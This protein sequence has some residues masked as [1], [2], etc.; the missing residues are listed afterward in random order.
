MHLLEIEQKESIAFASPG[1][2][3][4]QCLSIL[5]Q[6]KSLMIFLLFRQPKEQTVAVIKIHLAIFV[7][8]QKQQP[9]EY[10]LYYKS[11]KDWIWLGYQYFS[12]DKWWHI[13]LWAIV[14]FIYFIDLLFAW[15]A[16]TTNTSDQYYF[17]GI[18]INSY[19]GIYVWLLTMVSCVCSV[20]FFSLR[21]LD[22][23]LFTQIKDLNSIQRL[24]LLSK[25]SKV[26]TWIFIYSIVG[27]FIGFIVGFGIYKQSLW[28]L[29]ADKDLHFT[30]LIDSN[31][32]LINT[33]FYV[34]SSPAN[35]YG[36]S[37]HILASIL[38]NWPE[39]F[40]STFVFAFYGTI[41]VLY[42]K[43][44]E[45]TERL[46]EVAK[47][48]AQKAESDKQRVSFELEKIKIA[49]SREQ[50][51]TKKAKI[52]LRLQEVD[53]KRQLNNQE[54]ELKKIEKLLAI[55]AEMNTKLQRENELESIALEK[56]KADLAKAQM[57]LQKKQVESEYEKALITQLEIRK[58][59]D[60]LKLQFL[61]LGDFFHFTSNIYAECLDLIMQLSKSEQNPNKK[62]Q[63]EKLKIYI[64]HSINL[65]KFRYK[66]IVS[67]DNMIRLEEEIN[68][69]HSFKYIL[70]H[71]IENFTFN[72]DGVEDDY[73]MEYKI[74][75]GI[76]HELVWNAYKHSEFSSNRFAEVNI[77]IDT[78]GKLTC[79]II[80]SFDPTKM[81]ESKGSGLDITQKR[82][83]LTYAKRK[84][85]FKIEEPKIQENLPHPED[86]NAPN[87]ATYEINLE[88]QLDKV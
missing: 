19:E 86:Y 48:D 39:A 84:K 74:A 10:K 52:A 20:Y 60:Q 36:H 4:S 11:V 49:L 88:I 46:L 31:F 22:I 16:L 33:R 85:Y 51:E 75:S 53:A 29:I 2:E 38:R 67:K 68:A 79:C 8:R 81:T 40:M 70:D 76:I 42:P 3:C 45:N 34:D 32:L 69:I 1:G 64:Q 25:I 58:E 26:G 28:S 44:A 24:E 56:A 17:L 23:Y 59:E 63:L 18:S 66:S 77:R 7:L 82:L 14:S 57:E 21:K 78:K 62:N 13:R 50:E 5:V 83:D 6:A 87:Y 41:K 73:K 12:T 15:G 47:S 43:L 71:R 61:N 35:M 80:N 27:S 72:I 55:R 30:T 54:I 37:A 9:M 65:A